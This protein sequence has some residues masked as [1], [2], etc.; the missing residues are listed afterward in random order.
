MNGNGSIFYKDDYDQLYQ[1]DWSTINN[2]LD[3][4]TVTMQ[5]YVFGQQ[6]G[7]VRDNVIYRKGY[8]TVKHQVFKIQSDGYILQAEGTESYEDFIQMTYPCGGGPVDTFKYHL[9]NIPVDEVDTPIASGPRWADPDD[10]NDMYAVWADVN[11]DG[12]PV[13]IT[14]TGGVDI[15][16]W[17]DVW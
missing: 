9:N 12:S 16:E 14:A 7:Y 5:P 10:P 13:D 1:V 17:I 15:L 11:N 6:E 2:V 4:T 8:V 3:I